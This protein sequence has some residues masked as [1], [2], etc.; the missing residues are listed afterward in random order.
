[1]MAWQDTTRRG[2]LPARRGGHRGVG[3]AR[4]PVAPDERPSALAGWWARA[5]LGLFLAVFV[6]LGVLIG[7]IA[8][9]F[10]SPRREGVPR[11]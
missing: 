5:T 8:N 6:P 10:S 3:A 4:L 7:W 1:M 9:V 11:D 2:V